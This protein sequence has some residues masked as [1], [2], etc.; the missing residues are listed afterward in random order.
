MPKKKD[1]KNVRSMSRKKS[2]RIERK[3]K[4]KADKK[5]LKKEQKKEIKEAEKKEKEKKTSISDI[6]STVS[7]A[8]AVAK[9]ALGSF[10]SHLRVDVA[11]LKIKIAT[12]DAASTAVAYGAVTGALS[13]LFALLE[14]N[15][16][17]RF[18]RKAEMDVVCDFLGESPSAEIKISFSLR[19]WH[20][21]HVAFSALKRFIKHKLK[22]AA[23]NAT[24]S[25]EK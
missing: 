10:F 16:N 11:K 15:K 8:T 24:P 3:L 18:T 13:C 5:R 4:K 12:G 25:N 17:V 19:V 21:L 9:A 6:L 20:L 23:K 7:L 2:E 1:G 22:S 14:N